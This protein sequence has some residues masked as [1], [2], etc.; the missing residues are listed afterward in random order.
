MISLTVCV[1]DF[2]NSVLWDTHY[3]T[4][5]MQL[6][7][8]VNSWNSLKFSVSCKNKGKHCYYWMYSLNYSF[9]SLFPS[10]Y[11]SLFGN[12]RGLIG[13]LR[14][15]DVC[16]LQLKTLQLFGSLN[17]ETSVLVYGMPPCLLLKQIIMPEIA[18]SVQNQ[19]Q[20][21]IKIDFWKYPLAFL[22]VARGVY[23]GKSDC[24]VLPK[25]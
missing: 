21:G 10:P 16:F 2:Q 5:Y 14:S 19:E 15:T 6:V 22:L 23:S 11:L 25:N 1:W 13:E 8:H 7:L 9:K 24:L 4:S 12:V 18:A 3:G 17:P 20:K